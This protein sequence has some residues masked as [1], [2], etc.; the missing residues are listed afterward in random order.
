MV[1]F[2]VSPVEKH[3]S[4]WGEYGRGVAHQIE[5][6]QIGLS[7]RQKKKRNDTYWLAP[8]MNFSDCSYVAQA[9]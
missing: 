5:A 2:V 6:R 7:I 9:H 1:P 3:I 8:R 4:W